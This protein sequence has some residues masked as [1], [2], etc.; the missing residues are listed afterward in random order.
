MG[1]ERASGSQ[2]EGEDWTGIYREPGFSVIVLIK[3]RKNLK[4]IVKHTEKQ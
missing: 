3:K 4:K 1:A 2:S